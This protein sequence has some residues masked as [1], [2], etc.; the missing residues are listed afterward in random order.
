MDIRYGRTVKRLQS[1]LADG[2]KD[3]CDLY[4]RMTRPENVYQEL[5]AFKVVFTSI[6]TSE[7]AERIESKQVQMETL[8]KILETLKNMGIDLST[9]TYEETRNS[10]IKEWFGSDILDLIE[11]D[12]K[13][14]PINPNPPADEGGSGDDFSSTPVDV[15]DT[16]GGTPPSDLM[17]FGNEE[18][19]EENNTGD[20]GTEENN[21]GTEE[22]LGGDNAETP[23]QIPY[24]LK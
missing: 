12:E 9:G 8:D 5:P 7:D 15:Q 18:G 6:N 3:L 11:K 20:T 1:I 22:T 16:S 23:E 13:N 24:E 17:D 21:T 14:Q 4:L 2:L 10:L 19:T